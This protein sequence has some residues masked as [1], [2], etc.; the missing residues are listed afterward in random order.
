MRIIK[1]TGFYINLD[2]KEFEAVRIVRDILREMM[3]YS[4]NA[5]QDYKNDCDCEYGIDELEC[6]LQVVE[7]LYNS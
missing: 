7:G 1:P 3:E 5:E 2:D 4:V 6:A